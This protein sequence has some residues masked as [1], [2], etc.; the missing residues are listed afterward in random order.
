M[1]ALTDAGENQIN[2]DKAFRDCL[3]DK[4]ISNGK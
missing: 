2:Y 3:K 4:S 1:L